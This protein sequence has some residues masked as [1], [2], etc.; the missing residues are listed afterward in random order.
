MLLNKA[1]QTHCTPMYEASLNID[2]CIFLVSPQV[3]IA[4]QYAHARGIPHGRISASNIYLDRNLMLKVKSFRLFSTTEG[5]DTYSPPE[6]L[7][8]LR[9]HAHQHSGGSQQCCRAHGSHTTVT[10]NVPS[11]DIDN[12]NNSNNNDSNC[13]NNHNSNGNEH[14]SATLLDTAAD[15]WAVGCLLA[16]LL[17]TSSPPDALYLT[18]TAVPDPRLQLQQIFDAV[19]YAGVNEYLK[20]ESLMEPAAVEFLHYLQSRIVTAT[21]EHSEVEQGNWNNS[22]KGRGEIFDT[23]LRAIS[24]GTE[25]TEC[26]Y[27]TNARD[28]ITA[29]VTRT[30]HNICNGG[31]SNYFSPH[32]H[33]VMEP[34]YPLACDL[35]KRLLESSPFSR[36]C[37]LCAIFHPFFDS[38]VHGGDNLDP[39]LLCSPSPLPASDPLVASLMT[40]MSAVS[41]RGTSGPHKLRRMLWDIV[42]QSRPQLLPPKEFCV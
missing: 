31:N 36:P 34:M 30:G 23:L 32:S 33:L 16:S 10:R 22:E 3:L 21:P 12:S 14:P 42:S 27:N 15:I 17:L 28:H 2:H 6:R 13:N 19:G 5:T 40:Q 20:D 29:P 24:H 25:G 7:L 8:S 41:D 37:A 9:A 11:N 1:I 26:S 39:S 4:L 35:L 18:G 38:L